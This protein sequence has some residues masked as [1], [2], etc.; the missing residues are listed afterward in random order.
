M[1]LDKLSLDEMVQ[2]IETADENWENLLLHSDAETIWADAVRRRENI[3]AF[4][5]LASKWPTIVL[6]YKR[7]RSFTK[8]SIKAPLISIVSP[9]YAP[10]SAILS[11]ISNSVQGISIDVM[12]GEQ[13]IV[14][15]DKATPINFKSDTEI[16]ILYSYIGGDGIMGLNDSWD[17]QLEEG[18]VLF[19]FVEGECE[20]LDDD[21]ESILSNA[22]SVGSI[23]LLPS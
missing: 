9:N 18:A 5:R 21:F 4:C 12:W 15:I 14:D 10:F 6:K 3:N 22:K 8:K 17:F 23:V 20:W 19:T 1:T 11:G 2:G 7:V 16:S 13:Q